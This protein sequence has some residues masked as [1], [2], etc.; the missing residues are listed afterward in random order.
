M[1]GVEVGDGMLAALLLERLVAVVRAIKG[2]SN[3]HTKVRHED[4][5][6]FYMLQTETK[7]E[8]EEGRAEQRRQG[9]RLERV[10]RSLDQIASDVAEIK[11][12]R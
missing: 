6:E 4:A 12:R 5:H 9:D 3:G 8:L 10:E 1:S 7:L 2:K 11:H